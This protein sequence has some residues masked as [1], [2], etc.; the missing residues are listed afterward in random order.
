MGNNI[1][2]FIYDH[3][4]NEVNELD[5]LYLQLGDNVGRKDESFYIKEIMAYLMQSNH[6]DSDKIENWL[7]RREELFVNVDEL[8]WSSPLL[9]DDSLCDLNNMVDAFRAPTITSNVKFKIIRYLNKLKSIVDEELSIIDNFDW[10]EYIGIR[11]HCYI[12]MI[13]TLKKVQLRT[14][15]QS[16]IAKIFTDDVFFIVKKTFKQRQGNEKIYNKI[17]ELL[18]K[19]INQLE[20]KERPYFQPNENVHS[21]LQNYMRPPNSID[22]ILNKD[23]SSPDIVFFVRSFLGFIW[24]YYKA[25]LLDD[26]IKADSFCEIYNSRDIFDCSTDKNTMNCLIEIIQLLLFKVTFNSITNK[27]RDNYCLLEVLIQ[28]TLQF[29]Y[30]MLSLTSRNEKFISGDCEADNNIAIESKFKTKHLN[31]EML[32]HLFS[33]DGFFPRIIK[34]C[35]IIISILSTGVN[36]FLAEQGLVGPEMQA[37]LNN[38]ANFEE[39]TS[40]MLDYSCW[41]VCIITLVMRMVKYCVNIMNSIWELYSLLSLKFYSVHNTNLSKDDLY[42]YGPTNFDSVPR[43]IFVVELKEEYRPANL[44]NKS[45]GLINGFKYETVGENKYYWKLIKMQSASHITI[46]FDRNCHTNKNLEILEIFGP[47]RDPKNAINS[48]KFSHLISHYTESLFGELSGSRLTWPKEP[49]IYEGNELLVIFR[50]PLVDLNTAGD[51]MWQFR[52]YFQF[53]YWD[54]VA[55]NIFHE[56]DKDLQFQYREVLCNLKQ[57]FVFATNA[58]TTSLSFMLR[59]PNVCKIEDKFIEILDSP[60]FVGGM[61]NGND[62]VDN[63]CPNMIYYIKEDAKK[64]FSYKNKFSNPHSGLNSNFGKFVGL[65]YSKAENLAICE[66]GKEKTID[67]IFYKNCPNIDS[68]QSQ[69][70]NN[71]EWGLVLNFILEFSSIVYYNSKKRCVNLSIELLTD[72]K[73]M[74]IVKHDVITGQLGSEELSFLVRG[75]ICCHLHHLGLYYNT[76]KLI[77][78]IINARDDIKRIIHLIVR[79]RQKKEV[80]Y[81]KDH[82]FFLFILKFVFQTEFCKPLLSV[83]T[84]GRMYRSWVVM[85]KN[86]L[87][88]EIKKETANGLNSHEF[89]HDWLQFMALRISLILNLFPCSMG[90]QASISSNCN[91][92]SNSNKEYS[93]N[94]FD[95]GGSKYVY[96]LN[97][98][99]CH[100]L[101]SII[102]INKNKLLLNKSKRKAEIFV[103]LE[104][105]FIQD[106]KSNLIVCESEFMNINLIIKGIC[107]G[108]DK[109]VKISNHSQNITPEDIFGMNIVLII[110]RIRAISRCEAFRVIESLISDEDDNILLIASLVKS[111]RSLGHEYTCIPLHNSNIHGVELIEAESLHQPSFLAEVYQSNNIYHC[112][113]IHY[114]DHLL[115]C[116]KQIQIQVKEAY[117]KLLNSLTHC[118]KNS[119]IEAEMLKM[120]IFAHYSLKKMDNNYFSKANF[121]AKVLSLLTGCNKNCE[122]GNECIP[123][124]S[125][126]PYPLFLIFSILCTR[127]SLLEN[128]TVKLSLLFC[129]FVGLSHSISISGVFRGQLTTKEL[130]R[131]CEIY[132]MGNILIL[133]SKIRNFPKKRRVSKRE[134]KIYLEYMRYIFKRRNKINCPIDLFDIFDDLFVELFFIKPSILSNIIYRALESNNQ[135]LHI[136]CIKFLW[137][138]IPLISNDNFLNQYSEVLIPRYNLL[139]TGTNLSYCDCFEGYLEKIGE[140]LILFDNVQRESVI[141]PPAVL[142]NS[143]EGGLVESLNNGRGILF[144]CNNRFINGDDEFYRYFIILLRFIALYSE[145]NESMNMNI[146][147]GQ[148]H[149]G[150]IQL[151]CNQ[152]YKIPILLEELSSGSESIKWEDVY[153][154]IGTL[155]VITDEYDSEA[156]IGKILHFKENTSNKDVFWRTGVLI[157]NNP[158]KKE[159]SIL[160]QE[161]NSLRVKKFLYN[162][163]KLSLKGNIPFPTR[164]MIS[165]FNFNAI[166]LFNKI[167]RTAFK[168]LSNLNTHISNFDDYF[169]LSLKDGVATISNENKKKAI[170]IQMVSMSISFIHILMK[171]DYFSILN[172]EYNINLLEFHELINNLMNIGMVSK[173]SIYS[174]TNWQTS[175][176]SIV[177]NRRFIKRTAHNDK[178]AISNYYPIFKKST[179]ADLLC[180][181][182]FG[183]VRLNLPTKWSTG[184]KCFNCYKENVLVFNISQNLFHDLKCAIFTANCCIPISLSFY[185]FELNFSLV[186][187]LPFNSKFKFEPSFGNGY[188]FPF[189]IS[190]GLQRDGCPEGIP[191]SYGSYAYKNTGKLIHSNGNEEFIDSNIETFTVEDNIGCGID[192]LN[193]MVF[194][195]KNG[196]LIGRNPK[197][198]INKQKYNNK[199]YPMIDNA[200]GHFKPAI[201]IEKSNFIVVQSQYLVVN[202]NFGQERYK[203][204][205]INKLNCDSILSLDNEEL[206]VLKDEFKKSE[207][208]IER[209]DNYEISETDLN[210]RTMAFE[211]FEVIGTYDIPLSVC[212]SALKS[213]RDD[214][215]LAACLLLENRLED[216]TEIHT[217]DNIDISREVVSI[218]TAEHC[219]DHEY[220]NSTNCSKDD[221]MFDYLNSLR[222][223]CNGK[224]TELINTMIFRRQYEIIDLYKKGYFDIS[225][226]FLAFGSFGG[227][228]LNNIEISNLKNHSYNENIFRSFSKEIWFNSEF[229]LLEHTRKTISNEYSENYICC[230]IPW[231]GDEVTTQPKAV[232]NNITKQSSF[233]PGTIVGITPNIKYWI[234]DIYRIEN[235]NTENVLFDRL[236]T[237]IHLGTYPIF[238]IKYLLRRL[239][240]LTGVV[241]LFSK[242]TNSVLVQFF[243]YHS[244]VYYLVNLPSNLLVEAAA[245]IRNN[246]W[247]SMDESLI[248]SAA[249]QDYI[250]YLF[251]TGTHDQNGKTF[252]HL[253]LPHIFKVY[254]KSELIR[255]IELTRDVIFKNIYQVQKYSSDLSECELLNR[256][257]DILKIFKMVYGDKGPKHLEYFVP[258]YYIQDKHL[259]SIYYKSLM[260]DLSGFIKSLRIVS[261]KETRQFIDIV[262]G[263]YISNIKSSVYSHVPS[264]IIET[265]HPCTCMMDKK[266]DISFQDC[267]Y[268]LAIFDPLCEINSDNLSFLTVTI[269]DS[270]D[271]RAIDLF[272]KTGRELSGHKSIIPAN[273]FSFH[274][275]TSNQSDN[276]YGIKAYFVP[277]KYSIGDS[278]ILKNKNIHSS[279]LLLDLIIENGDDANL[280]FY[281]QTI[282]EILLTILFEIHIPKCNMPPKV[283]TSSSAVSLIST[284]GNAISMQSSFIHI[285]Q[286]LIYILVKHPEIICYISEK[287]VIILDY[288]SRFFNSVYNSQMDQL[289]IV[290][291]YF[292]S[293][294]IKF[295]LMLQL[296]YLIYFYRNCD[297]LFDN[298]NIYS[299]MGC[300]DLMDFPYFKSSL[301]LQIQHNLFAELNLAYHD[302]NIRYYYKTGN[303]IFNIP[304]KL[305]YNKFKESHEYSIS[306]FFLNGDLKTHKLLSGNKTVFNF[307][308]WYNFIST[309]NISI[310]AF[311]SS[312]YNIYLGGVENKKNIYLENLDKSSEISK[313]ELHMENSDDYCIYE[314]N[315]PLVLVEKLGEI[316]ISILDAVIIIPP[317]QLHSNG[318]NFSVDITSFITEMLNIMDKKVLLLPKNRFLWLKNQRLQAQLSSFDEPIKILSNPI[319]INYSLRRVLTDEVILSK[320]ITFGCN[321]LVILRASALDDTQ[322]RV[323]LLWDILTNLKNNYSSI[324]SSSSTCTWKKDWENQFISS[325]INV[326]NSFDPRI[327]FEYLNTYE[328]RAFGGENLDNRSQDCNTTEYY[329]PFKSPSIQLMRDFFLKSYSEAIFQRKYWPVFI[330]TIP[331]RDFEAANNVNCELNVR[332]RELSEDNKTCFNSSNVSNLREMNSPCSISFWIFPGNIK[333]SQN[334]F[335]VS[336]YK[337]FDNYVNRLSI[338]KGYSLSEAH[339]SEYLNSEQW[340]LILYRGVTVSTISFWITD[341]GKLAIIINSPKKNYPSNLLLNYQSMSQ[342]NQ[343]SDTTSFS[344]YIQNKSSI[345]EYKT[346]IIVS[347]RKIN[348]DQWNHIAV[349]IGLSRE[350]EDANE[351]KLFGC[352]TVKLYING[353]FDERKEIPGGNI[354]LL[355][356]DLPWVIGYPEYW[357]KCLFNNSGLESVG[358]SLI[359]HLPNIFLGQDIG[360][361][362]LLNCIGPN[363]KYLN[364]VTGEPLFGLVA[365]LI[366]IHFEWG[367]ENIHDYIKYTFDC[368]L[369]QDDMDEASHSEKPFEK[370]TSVK[371]QKIFPNSGF[372]RASKYSNSLIH[373]FSNNWKSQVIVSHFNNIW[374]HEYVNLNNPMIDY[375]EENIKNTKLNISVPKVIMHNKVFSGTNLYVKFGIVVLEKLEIICSEESSRNIDNSANLETCSCKESPIDTIIMIGKYRLEDSLFIIRLKYLNKLFNGSTLYKLKTELDVIFG[376]IFKTPNYMGSYS[377]DQSSSYQNIL[378]DIYSNYELISIFDYHL[379]TNKRNIGTCFQANCDEFVAFHRTFE[380]KNVKSKALLNEEFQEIIPSVSE[381]INYFFDEIKLPEYIFGKPIY[382]KWPF[383]KEKVGCTNCRIAILSHLEVCNTILRKM[384]ALF[385]SIFNFVEIVSPRPSV[386]RLSWLKMM[387]RYLSF[388]MKEVLINLCLELTESSDADGKIRV[389]INRPRSIFGNKKIKNSTDKFGL[390]TVFGQLYSILEKIPFNRFRCKKRP[391]Y[392]IYEGEG[393]IDAG[394]IYRDL[395]SHLCIELQSE[396]LQLFVLCPNSNGYGDDQFFFVPNPS[397]G[398]NTHASLNDVADGSSNNL[399][400]NCVCCKHNIYDSLYAFVGR[401]MGI[402]IR[403]Q[404]PLNLDIPTIIWKLIL[405]E[406]AS[407]SDLKQIDWYSAKFYE[408]LKYIESIWEASN[409]MHETNRRQILEEFH[410]LDL[411]WSCLNVNGEVV[412]LKNGG[413]RLP[414]GIDELGEY[415]R[416]YR[417]FKLEREFL[418]ATNNIRKG[419]TN[420][421]PEVVLELQTHEELEKLICGSPSIDV[422]LLKQHTKYSGYSPNDEIICWL[423]DIISEMT[424]VQQQRFLRFVW[425]RSRLPNRGA[426]WENNMEIVRAYGN[427][428]SIYNEMATMVENNQT[429]EINE[430]EHTNGVY[431]SLTNLHLEDEFFGDNNDSLNNISPNETY[432]TQRAV[433]NISQ[434]S[435]AWRWRED[436]GLLPTSHT[437]FFQLELPMYSSKEVLRERLLYAITEGITIDIDN[438]ASSTIWE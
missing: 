4:I 251:W 127:C 299:Q 124:V 327:Y 433:S 32:E 336:N 421:V 258:M 132:F 165:K 377:N 306:T 438:V 166:Q 177:L 157:F 309:S 230:T 64:R 318:N 328:F 167:L 51:D 45:Q 325:K 278:N 184:S 403:T 300:I 261:K 211:L 242:A 311:I 348:M 334:T 91:N 289:Q 129:S 310:P 36:H 352:H 370:S 43:N 67:D 350:T 267:D 106:V 20:I 152:L 247:M 49:I 57:V 434:G 254:F 187:E 46:T 226:H 191:G 401:L 42:C 90:E 298:K 13:I 53:H 23:D 60:L 316:H 70:I 425:G 89:I 48:D 320:S 231:Q 330:G 281:I 394:G 88:G 359:G 65:W 98:N 138:F 76:F 202:A 233:P 150:F 308:P 408:K 95:T 303:N 417:E 5:K 435:T 409:N 292:Q 160:I 168:Y 30:D 252:F 411:R 420:I 100:V 418:H 114:T 39:L 332:S 207:L 273:F 14:Q 264:I 399:S 223:S 427:N 212:L 412:E 141:Q 372:R 324:N 287:S 383:F 416:V 52:V 236:G 108:I 275:V 194:F 282:V 373:V 171:N 362:K 198:N 355:S 215:D 154:C 302:S 102:D 342:K 137:K 222:T 366:V 346:T 351:S 286:Q 103:E 360:N 136:Y 255:C 10:D 269:K 153:K 146:G 144:D 260:S 240:G 356:G 392:V 398:V 62:K 280:K 162:S 266:Y 257:C 55:D 291:N 156:Y 378:H 200:R 406:N 225:R 385:V 210:R 11:L 272:K 376:K 323:Q 270:I 407:L 109:F 58:V 147:S 423:W 379:K 15:N 170:L 148:V 38:I 173:P 241:W 218:D 243:D 50:T 283:L 410:S 72:N 301:E 304:F 110:R 415:C 92:I 437:C 71:V 18:Y 40:A 68:I 389:S 246:I 228:Q 123:S 17:M 386:F 354:P 239:S 37:N 193:H 357:R 339:I 396:R 365:N 176:N 126:G 149:H 190:I 224:Y 274:L 25:M 206:L 203:Y 319:L 250:E 297:V 139:K 422:D 248:H 368:I 347:N 9:L 419:I 2:L 101:E 77:E 290:T 97:E 28:V 180:N 361:S 353:L 217:K 349:T 335:S 358:D 256:N 8:I 432:F 314:P 192:L 430:S 436:D 293:V 229:D 7:K 237:V 344:S 134:Q 364:F 113:D 214:L 93:Y 245:D 105:M 384:S 112:S 80:D 414:V 388:S 285:V 197:L 405:G 208:G 393:G 186:D 128:S 295:S 395:L 307:C 221:Y 185:Y 374:Q 262:V 209:L 343:N 59:G 131:I 115:G 265:S 33:D 397:L 204:E 118:K 79:N 133:T 375:K 390:D 29:G 82:A 122:L 161:R 6:I 140:S 54:H 84:L 331:I 431:N 249:F 429:H 24:N 400:R 66:M 199:E 86:K 371:N 21:F 19:L 73:F 125:P 172:L 121:P 189:H 381:Y 85:E 338:Y 183:N 313:D 244:L 151:L 253:K 312:I 205:Y 104:N 83:W 413:E 326:D 382:G 130:W 294:N 164:F 238:R 135:V 213:C 195:T 216:P 75:Y 426:Q 179:Q 35:F 69:I 220:M 219:N 232:F 321:E 44:I 119:S 178:F 181:S 317:D 369:L 340:K 158:L 155:A 276:K 107:G 47:T 74:S 1:D 196:R 41:D 120:S 315:T 169:S 391:W 428:D 145:G 61:S 96:Y 31:Y 271:G 268:F 3:A 26:D 142:L 296:H 380:L 163:I 235:F 404:I 81:I 329:S 175:I 87:E 182:P 305:N 78:N 367:M 174:N 16:Y 188:K 56:M 263:D 99:L 234:N 201:W 322:D 277:I 424:A 284:V 116:G 341:Q 333:N 402:S 94:F 363:R 387:K 159:Y 34:V 22:Q 288:L 117:Y 63:M 143:S 111:L 227:R 12:H 279:Y 27:S 345:I 259:L 337:K